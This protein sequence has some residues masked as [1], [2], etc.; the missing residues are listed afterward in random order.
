M[1]GRTL[2]EAGEER[3]PGSLCANS[4]HEVSRVVHCGSP[5]RDS[6]CI[7]HSNRAYKVRTDDSK[8]IESSDAV[9]QDLYVALQAASNEKCRYA[10]HTR[11]RQTLLQA[12]KGMSE[13]T[14][15]NL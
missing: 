2:V 8:S 1:P 13:D 11:A 9:I 7:S 4:S 5:V 12:L 10:T 14:G 6:E 3:Y 15:R